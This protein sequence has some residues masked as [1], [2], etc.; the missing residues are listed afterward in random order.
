[1]PGDSAIVA[2]ELVANSK[3][4]L[5]FRLYSNY[6]FKY[7]LYDNRRIS[8]YKMATIILDYVIGKTMYP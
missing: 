6:C 1:M 7:W 8:L 3:L 4:Q 2:H 5:E